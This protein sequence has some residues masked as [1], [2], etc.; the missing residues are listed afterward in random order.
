MEKKLTFRI[1]RVC[2]NVVYPFGV[3]RARSSNQAMNLIAFFYEKL[4]EIAAI[5]A[6]D[7][8]D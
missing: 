3:E 6:G 4:G 1:M 8:G 7:A 2:I 5:L